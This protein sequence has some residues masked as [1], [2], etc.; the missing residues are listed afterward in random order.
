MRYKDLMKDPK[1]RP[2]F[3]IG[4]GNE[5]GRIFQGIPDIV[6]PDTAFL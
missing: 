6:G 5:L 2:L 3:E 1:N 4:F